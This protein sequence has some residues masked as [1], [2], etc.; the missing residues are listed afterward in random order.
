[1][2]L[3]DSVGRPLHARPRH[4]SPRSQAREL[5]DRRL[6]QHQNL[7]LWLR[8]RGDPWRLESDLLWIEVVRR[9]RDTPGSLFYGFV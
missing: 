9:P 8:P 2:D 1:V 4:R 7:R 6:R 3:P 5:T